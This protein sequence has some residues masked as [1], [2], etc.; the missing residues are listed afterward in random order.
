[1]SCHVEKDLDDKE[2]YSVV[3][4]IAINTGMPFDLI[5]Q[6][7]LSDPIPYTGPSIDA[8]EDNTAEYFYVNVLLFTNHAIPIILPY[9]YKSFYTKEDDQKKK[10]YKNTLKHWILSNAK[11]TEWKHHIDAFQRVGR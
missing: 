10:Q 1:M 6:I 7:M 8:S 3:N 9:V 11:G 4:K 5:K 2:N